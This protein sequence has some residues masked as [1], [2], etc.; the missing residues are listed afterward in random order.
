MNQRT[1]LFTWLA[2]GTGNRGHFSE[3]TDTLHMVECTFAPDSVEWVVQWVPRLVAYRLHFI[4]RRDGNQVF[5]STLDSWNRDLV[6]TPDS[7]ILLANM[8]WWTN[9]ACLLDD[10]SSSDTLNQVY[11]T[12]R[13][14]IAHTLDRSID[15]HLQNW[16]SEVLIWT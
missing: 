1:Y 7:K 10:A 3:P 14:R 15:A 2:I 8:V 11:D 16:K 13:W 6:W 9:D 12:W 4:T 5:S